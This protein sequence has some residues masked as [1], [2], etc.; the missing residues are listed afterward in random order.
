V[1]YVGLRHQVFIFFDC[2]P[3]IKKNLGAMRP[4]A[5]LMDAIEEFP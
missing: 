2:L 4:V 5:D 3:K 1:P